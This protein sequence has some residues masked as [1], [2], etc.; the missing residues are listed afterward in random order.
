MTCFCPNLE[1]EFQFF[2]NNSGYKKDKKKILSHLFSDKYRVFRNDCKKVWV[3][4][5]RQET[6]YKLGQVSFY[7]LDWSILISSFQK[8]LSPFSNF[9]LWKTFEVWNCENMENTLKIKVFIKSISFCKYLRNGSSDLYEILCGGQILSCELKFEISWRSVHECAHTSCKRA[10]A[11]Y[12][13]NSHVF[14][15][16]ARIYG[17]IFM[18]FQT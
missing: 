15:S 8:I 9:P 17:W 10:C 4:C 16:Y 12:I 11:R 13:A 14:N 6:T 18:K 2:Q 1:I 3:Y 7:S 5:S